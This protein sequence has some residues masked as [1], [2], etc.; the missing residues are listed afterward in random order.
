VRVEAGAAVP[1]AGAI[2]RCRPGPTG[3]RSPRFGAG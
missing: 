3:C 1:L 2:Y